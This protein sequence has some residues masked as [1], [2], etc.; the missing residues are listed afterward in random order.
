V[1]V[2]SVRTPHACLERALQFKADA[3]QLKALSNQWYAV[4]YFY[5]AYHTVRASIMEDPIFQDPSRLKALNSSWEGPD[6]WNDHHQ[7]RRGNGIVGAPGITDLV[8]ELYIDISIE[9]VQLHSA[10]I[11][12]RYGLGLAGY[13]SEALTAAFAK[14]ATA[15]TAGELVA[16]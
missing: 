5:A 1:S 10:S 2:S 13:T 7:T 16:P 15:A 3:E 14:I 9:Y 12:V 4:S 8:K 6:R 11:A